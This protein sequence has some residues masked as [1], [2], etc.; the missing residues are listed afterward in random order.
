MPLRFLLVLG[1]LSWMGCKPSTAAEG[2]RLRVLTSIPPLYSWAANVVGDRADLQNLLPPNVGPHDYEFRPRDLRKVQEADIIFINGLGVESWLTKAIAANDPGA[3]RKI[4]EVAAG[5]PT[6]TLIYELPALHLSTTEPA[7]L[8]SHVGAANP[9]LWLDPGFARQAV[10]NLLA[11]LQ[12]ADPINAAAYA[13]NAAAYQARLQ[14]LDQEFRES[15]EGLT[16]REVVTFHDAFPYLCRRYGLNLVGVIEEVP[17]ASPSPRYLA[18][19]S[20]VIR[21]NRVSAIFVEPQ[22]DTKLARQLAKDLEVGVAPLDTLETGRLA[23]QSYED[24]MR[25]NLKALKR[26]LR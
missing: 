13:T 4:V 8:H 19:L 5:I 26:A 1:L 23:P 12:R 7:E 17:G 20:Q 24:G 10:S 16:R 15:L 18:E 6:N 9:H 25:A 2:K 22:F 14:A 3:D 11:V 21:G